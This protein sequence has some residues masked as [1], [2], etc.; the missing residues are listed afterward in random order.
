M[1]QLIRSEIQ[2]SRIVHLL[3]C[4]KDLYNVH[5]ARNEDYEICVEEFMD[6]ISLFVS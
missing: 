6:L 5:N 2:N 3:W 4:C 1:Q